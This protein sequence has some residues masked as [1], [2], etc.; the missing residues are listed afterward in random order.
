M[1]TNNGPHELPHW[2]PDDPA[3]TYAPTGREKAAWVAWAIVSVPVAWALRR[4][5]ACLTT[6]RPSWQTLAHVAFV[7][8][9]G[10]WL[11]RGLTRWPVTAD[12]STTV[13]GPM[14]AGTAGA[15]RLRDLATASH[16]AA[17]ATARAARGE[18]MPMAPG[19]PAIA[20]A[21]A[22]D[23]RAPSWLTPGVRALWPDVVDAAHGVSEWYG[24]PLDA[25][26]WAA[27]V[28]R[29]CPTGDAACESYAGA[30]GPSQLMPETAAA[31]EAQ[32]GLRCTE[33]N[34]VDI[35][36]NLRCG[37]Y[38]LTGRIR[39]NAWAWS[40]DNEEP[41]I[42][43]GAIEYNDGQ[44]AGYNA[45]AAAVKAGGDA[46]AAIP[47]HLDPSIYCYHVQER[48][49]ASMAERGA[50]AMAGAGR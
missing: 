1:N 25:H 3:V 16:D 34:P 44:R 43:L 23:E 27:L 39:N 46:C 2:R 45:A 33:R 22:G 24:V 21:P 37:A 28:T 29:E 41:A 48:W 6:P 31:I 40:A 4:G 15:E 32:T 47:R 38:Y 18:R 50:V 13:R 30:F 36:T 42:L 5:R 7:V 17:T 26:V 49:R 11:Y 8:F 14:P 12:A 19:L 9:C 20:V 35:P 10:V